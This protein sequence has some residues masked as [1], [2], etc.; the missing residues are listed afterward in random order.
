SGSGGYGVRKGGDGHGIRLLV[1]VE[2]DREGID[3]HSVLRLMCDNACEYIDH[4]IVF[5][6]EVIKDFALVSSML[7]IWIWALDG[8]R[9][10]LVASVRS[11]IE[12]ILLVQR[13]IQLVVDVTRAHLEIDVI[14]RVDMS[15][16]LVD[17]TRAHLEIDV[18]VRVDM[19]NVSVNVKYL[20]TIF[21][22][23][24]IKRG[25]S[26]ADKS[27]ASSLVLPSRKRTPWVDLSVTARRT[28]RNSAAA[29]A[30]T[31][32][33]MT[34][35]MSEGSSKLG[36][37]RR[38][39]LK[40]KES[41]Q[42]R[43]KG[44]EVI[45]TRSEEWENSTLV[46]PLRKRTPTSRN[47]AAGRAAVRARTT[48]ASR[49]EGSSRLGKTRN[50]TDR[51]MAISCGKGK[52]VEARMKT[53]KADKAAVRARTTPASRSEGSSRLG[54][55]RNMTDREKGK[56]VEARHPAARER[57]ISCAKGKGSKAD[58]AVVAGVSLSGTL[59]SRAREAV[60]SRSEEWGKSSIMIPI[61]KRTPRFV[62][63]VEATRKRADSRADARASTTVVAGREGDSRSGEPSWMTVVEKVTS[64]G[65]GKG[66][67][68]RAR[69]AT[70]LFDETRPRTLRESAPIDDVMVEG[71]S[72]WA[73]RIANNVLKDLED[74][75]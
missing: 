66:M 19:S 61:R 25:Y 37:T 12:D 29:R 47:S 1:R 28:R 53:S 40:Q 51:E 71:A 14:V 55:T 32:D 8:M 46:I 33:S 43:G 44:V 6:G 45:A 2:L 22:I 35:A 26:L 39:T 54:K 67:G 30:A 41:S 48:P 11:Y 4:G 62:K 73:L 58:K 64:G 21:V 24:V 60:N 18:I 74:T 70:S 7:D 57:V 56:R 34:P 16:V 38:M 3:L 69:K 10:F 15:N 9:E 23:R 20:I 17:V 36:K 5:C 75:D 72:D 52:G 49:S 68:V 63:S 50:M 13:V 31:E 59:R 27:V 65:K 42:G